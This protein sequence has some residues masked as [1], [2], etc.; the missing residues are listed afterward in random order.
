MN[1]QPLL[2]SK[3]DTRATNATPLYHTLPSRASQRPKILLIEDRPFAASPE[4]N[5]SSDHANK[6]GHDKQAPECGVQ[7]GK[8]TV[9]V[10]RF[11]I[12]SD[13]G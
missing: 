1:S 4:S 10:I 6:N 11:S 12:S 9:Y 7:P 5:E 3:G 13:P 2:K 8:L